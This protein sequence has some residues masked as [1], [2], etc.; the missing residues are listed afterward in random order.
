MCCMQSRENFPQ[1]KTLKP[2][3]SFTSKKGEKTHLQML[4][5]IRLIS[6]TENEGTFNN[7]TRQVFANMD[8]EE[9]SCSWS[10]TN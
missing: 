8:L 7:K 5:I 4:Q 10:L 9:Q 6:T 3:L 1:D 2:S